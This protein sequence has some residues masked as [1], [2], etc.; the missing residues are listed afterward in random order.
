VTAPDEETPL[1]D[2]PETTPTGSNE[3]LEGWS[4]FNLLAT[5]VAL[6]LLVFFFIKFFLNRIRLEEYEEEPVD[7]QLWAA[8]S[9]EQRAQYKAR[10]EADYQTWLADRQRHANR[11]RALL[12]NVPVLLIA[13]VAFVEALIVLFVTQD[14]SLNMILVDNYSVIFALIVFVQF[15]T[16]MV[17]GIIRNSRR[18]NQLQ[19]TTPQATSESGDIT[20]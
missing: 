11:P 14:F 6:L 10:R 4:L 5:I 16:P 8:M 3:P 19:Q 15:L 12:V 17:A 1:G 9:P 20:L 7:S 13:A 18:E 2:I